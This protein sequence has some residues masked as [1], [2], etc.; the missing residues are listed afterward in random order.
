MEQEL[1]L[2]TIGCIVVLVW[3]L[4]TAHDTYS[5]WKTIYKHPINILI[6]LANIGG[7]FV[8]LLSCHFYPVVP[9]FIGKLVVVVVACLF[10]GFVALTISAMIKGK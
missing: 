2:R 10:I 9:L 1:M 6:V 7:I 5:G 8:A 3:I 4:K